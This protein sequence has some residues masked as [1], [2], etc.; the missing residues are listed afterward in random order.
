[1]VVLDMPIHLQKHDKLSLTATEVKKLWQ[2]TLT[3]RKF[4]DEDVTV[5]CV[6]ATES[7]AL[8]HQYRGKQQPTNVLTF[9]YDTRE[10]DI[11]LCLEVVER[12]A[13]ER[14]LSL[15]DYTALVLVHALLH[16]SG[17]DHERSD[18]EAQQTEELERAILGQTGF[19]SQHLADNHG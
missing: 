10:H 17:L 19:S 4:P 5:R 16:V 13:E 3:A 11:A 2:V 1:M 18:E 12:E 6:S 14:Q 9:S 8:Y 7:E 15:R